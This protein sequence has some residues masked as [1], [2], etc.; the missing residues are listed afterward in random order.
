MLLGDKLHSSFF[1]LAL[2][3]LARV[4][5]K[6]FPKCSVALDVHKQAEAWRN[7]HLYDIQFKFS[8]IGKYTG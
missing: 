8:L 5:F 4:F 3:K 1:V 7:I 6:H 2:L